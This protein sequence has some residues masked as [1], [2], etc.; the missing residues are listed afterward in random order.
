MVGII[1]ASR[2]AITPISLLITV[3]VYL[4]VNLIRTAVIFFFYPIMKRVGYGIDRREAII[5]SWGGL[6]GALGLALALLVSYTV[7]IPEEI[8]DQ[9]LLMTAGVVTLTLTVNATTIRKLLEK[10][11]LTSVSNAESYVDYSVR[12]RVNEES[13]A[14]LEKIGKRESLADADWDQVRSYLPSPEKA[15]DISGCSDEE[16]LHHIRMRLYGTEVQVIRQLHSEGYVTTSTYRL[17]INSQER[18]FDS[19]GTLPLSERVLVFARFEGSGFMKFIM[20]HEWTKKLFHKN[21]DRH[22]ESLFDLGSAFLAMQRDSIEEI[23]DFRKYDAF[24]NRADAIF[25]QL[26]GEINGNISLT[27]KYLSDFAAAYPAL[28]RSA[29]TQKAARMLLANEK[30]YVRLLAEDGILSEKDAAHIE[31]D[32]DSVQLK[33]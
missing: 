27:E 5:L 1:I 2:V 32:I 20:K 10:L 6:R 28:H 33:A 14:Y 23:Q 31:N 7:N 22:V 21:I 12:S 15:P 3:G 17:L 16:L 25:D 18:H 9:I 11:G 8:R 4:G 29:A 30:K 19:N 13:A 24:R 26:L